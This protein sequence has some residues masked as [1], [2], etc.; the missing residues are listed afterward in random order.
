M[1]FNMAILSGYNCQTDSDDKLKPKFGPLLDDDAPDSAIGIIEL[2]KLLDH[3]W[4]EKRI[5]KYAKSI[6]W[7]YKLDAWNQSTLK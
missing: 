2:R 3:I 1:K 6:R 7:V 4:N 5:T